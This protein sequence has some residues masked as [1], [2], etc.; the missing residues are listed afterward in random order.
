M[1]CQRG[2][3]RGQRAIVGILLYIFQVQPLIV[4]EYRHCRRE[5][6]VMQERGEKSDNETGDNETGNDKMTRHKAEKNEKK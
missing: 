6:K 2:G 4:V 1:G 3:H 5:K